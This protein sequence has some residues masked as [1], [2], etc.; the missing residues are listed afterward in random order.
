MDI[1]YDGL[2]D[3]LDINQL[4]NC[5]RLFVNKK[6]KINVCSSKKCNIVF[7][8][9]TSDENSKFEVNLDGKQNELLI[10]GI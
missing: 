5:S 7:E 8:N 1:N 4:K 3:K 9:F 6:A 2:T 10:K